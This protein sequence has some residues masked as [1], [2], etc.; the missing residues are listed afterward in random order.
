MCMIN[1]L[2]KSNPE[3][4][5]GEKNPF[6]KSYPSAEIKSLYVLNPNEQG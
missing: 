3:E 1:T 6:K 5:N 4:K 2:K